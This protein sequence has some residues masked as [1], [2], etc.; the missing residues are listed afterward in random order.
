[1]GGGSVSALTLY[2]TLQKDLREKP[3]LGVY[4]LCGTE[5]WFVEQATKLITGVALAGMDAALVTLNLVDLDARNTPVSRLV[6][7]VT[8]P[9]FMA[10]RKV[11]RVEHCPYFTPRQSKGARLEAEDEAGEDVAGLQGLFAAFPPGVTLICKATAVNARLKLT[12]A[13]KKCGAVYDFTSAKRADALRDAETLLQKELK[14]LGVSIEAR[15]A[16]ELLT[17]I[18][19][20]EKTP[21]VRQL[22][23]ESSKLAAFKGY[24]GVVSLAD[25]AALVPRSAEAKV[26]LF[27][28]AFSQHN[29]A[30]ALWH[31]RQLWQDGEEP[32]MVLSVFARH[33]RQ[34]LLARE[35]LDEGLTAEAVAKTLGGHPFVA[36]KLVAAASTFDPARLRELLVSCFDIDNKGKSGRADI[37]FALERMIVPQ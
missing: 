22:W 10:A 9:P 31:L 33:V 12:G 24:T 5:E 20:D 32:L 2:E 8:T 15:A 14:R 28:D 34:M 1:M 7:E 17:L 27:T 16:A 11:V 4:V 29:K 3:L 26:F 19:V 30:Q 35:M 18:G 23:Q 25:V 36:G 6:Q 13:A 37:A 21:H